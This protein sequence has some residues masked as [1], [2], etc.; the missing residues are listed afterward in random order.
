MTDTP[1]TVPDQT[2]KVNPWVFVPLV[3]FMQ[4]IPVAIVQELSLIFYKDLGIANDRITL[5]TSLISLPWSMQML[6]GPLV[7]LT[8][9]KRWWILTMQL[10]IAACLIIAG[11]IIKTDHAFELGLVI[12]ATTAFM[13]TLCNIATD[14]FYIITTTKDQQAKFVGI[15]TTSSRL[16]RLFCVGILVLVQGL[17]VKDAKLEPMTAWMIV[18]L[19]C[20]AIYALGHVVNRRFLP[21]PSVDAPREQAEPN[22]LQRNILR[23]LNILMLGVGGY[24]TLNAIVRLFAHG[25]WSFWDGSISFFGRSFDITGWR[26]PSRNL[27]LRNDLHLTSIE[28]ELLQLAVCGGI[29]IGGF[30][31]GKKLIRGTPMADSFASFVKQPGFPAILGFV[32]FYR[33]GEAMIA[34]MTP[35]FLKAPLAEGG[36]AIPN[37]QLGPIKGFA[38]VVGIIIGGIAGGYIVSKIGLRKAFWPLALSMHIPNLLYLCAS[39]GTLPMAYVDLPVLGH[40]SLTLGGI[41]FVD[42]FGYGFGFSAYMIYMMW[43]A[44]R[45]NYKTSHYAIC[46][47]MGALCI[48][49]AGIVSGQIQVN[50]G[51]TDFFWWVMA[52]TIPG[53]LSILFIPLDDSH[54]Q[55]KVEAIE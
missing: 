20:A 43:V 51:Y 1:A 39:Y 19:G 49:I 37:E 22:E 29:V 21:R 27:V 11:F 46:A 14:G 10:A 16:G 33:F 25:M 28:V 8:K 18:L 5:W 54:R 35:L 13:S 31:I 38:G 6:F 41:E 26:L 17:L 40:F 47:G 55:I 45:G 36:L 34:K 12:L 23:T 9:T 2:S 3:Y 44:Q 24:F 50:V 42:Q 52:L 4:S 48:A 32:L 7:E 53:M 15:L 30:L